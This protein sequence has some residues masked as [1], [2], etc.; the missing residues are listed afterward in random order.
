VQATRHADTLVFGLS[1]RAGI[2]LYRAAKALA[3]VRRRDF[4]LP[5]DVRDLYVPVCA[6]R[7]ASRGATGRS[8]EARWVLAEI[9]NEV[10]VP[11]A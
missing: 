5:D 6:H 10:P 8:R 7:L 1:T 11:V 4:V 2:H 3:L 9:L